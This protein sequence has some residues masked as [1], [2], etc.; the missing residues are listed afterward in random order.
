MRGVLFEP[1]EERRLDS[2]GWK[3]GSRSHGSHEKGK[4]HKDCFQG[5]RGAGEGRHKPTVIGVKR[6]YYP[7]Q[8][9]QTVSE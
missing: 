8:D 9:W 2:Y 6:L 4:N 3:K 5:G 7:C 1:K